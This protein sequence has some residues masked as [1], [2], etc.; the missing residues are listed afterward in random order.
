ML[1]N[2]KG[3]VTVHGILHVIEQQDYRCALTGMLLEP[4]DAA[5]DHKTPISRGGKHTLD[6]IQVLN[7]DVNRAKSTLNNDEFIAL[8]R[9]VVA[10]ADRVTSN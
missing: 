9:Q 3:T 10:W 5:L 8:C 2:A 4:E 1:S 7:R 6:N